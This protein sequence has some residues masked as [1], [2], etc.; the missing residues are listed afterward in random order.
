MKKLLCAVLAMCLCFAVCGCN[1]KP[2][3]KG[4]KSNKA[5]SSSQS[6]QSEA[7]TTSNTVSSEQND[8]DEA[9]QVYAADRK[10]NA[11]GVTTQRTLSNT[12]YKLKTEKKLNVL[13]FGGSV[14][15]GSSSTEGN[16]W[17][18]KTGKWLKSTYSDAN[19]TCVNAALGGTSAYFGAFRFETDVLPVKPDLMFIEFAVNDAYEGVNYSKSAYYLELLIK[20]INK[21]L[22][23]TDVVI[24]LITD[25]GK[26]GGEFECG[27]AHKAIADYYGIPCIDVGAALAKVIKDEGSD[28]GDYIGDYV[29]PNDKGHAVYADTII[30]RLKTL[31]AVEAKGLKKHTLPKEDYIV[32]GVSMNCKVITA[33]Q[34]KNSGDWKLESGRCQKYTSYLTPTKKGDKFTIEFEGTS[35]G[36]YLTTPTGNT[37][38]ATIDGS[39]KAYVVKPDTLDGE[40]E[41]LVFDNLISGK[42]TVEIEYVS[43]NEF[44]I[45]AFF[46]G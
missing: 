26:L 36:M 11:K 29:H 22:P 28:W 33:D 43:Y 39:E 10:Y 13:Y 15:W 17:A 40:H 25:K 24:I 44:K 23:Q 32:G 6:Q 31:L 30:A 46:I 20:K 35:F 37:V 7:P 38:V 3:S 14:T 2:E 16:S 27:K 5:E 18:S 42:H 9:V 1:K 12:V 21:E 41:K 45:F 34:V 4:K 19:V 8:N